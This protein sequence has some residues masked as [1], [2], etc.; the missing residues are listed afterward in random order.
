[1]TSGNPAKDP[2]DDRAARRAKIDA[3]APRQGKAKPALVALVVVLTVIALGTAVFFG[4]RSQT[5]DAEPTAS[6]T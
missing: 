3:A 6:S 1:M 4:I 5:P 2:R